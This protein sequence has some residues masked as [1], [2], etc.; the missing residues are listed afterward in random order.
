MFTN[1]SFNCQDL[2]KPFKKKKNLTP[3][4]KNQAKQE[5]RTSFRDTDK[6][7]YL[8]K[9]DQLMKKFNKNSELKKEFKNLMKFQEKIAKY[10]IPKNQYYMTKMLNSITKRVKDQF[11]KGFIDHFSLTCQSLQYIKKSPVP[12]LS[13]IEEK[14]VKFSPVHK[15]KKLKFN[16]KKYREKIVNF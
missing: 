9:I 3:N 7:K 14:M 13:Q 11:S 6:S 16:R 12:S 10:Q 1:Y 4:F 2:E 15:G 8:Q 5:F